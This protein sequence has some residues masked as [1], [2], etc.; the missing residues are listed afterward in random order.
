RR[1]R[2]QWLVGPCARLHL[3]EKTSHLRMSGKTMLESL[4]CPIQDH[5]GFSSGDECR[6]T[7][8]SQR[9]L[10]ISLRTQPCAFGL[11]A[12][13]ERQAF[14]CVGAVVWHIPASSVRGAPR[15]A[16]ECLVDEVD[17]LLEVLFQNCLDLG[18]LP[19]DN[20]HQIC[21]DHDAVTE[22][23]LRNLL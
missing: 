19:T 13:A 11:H 9:D 14:L 5:F 7:A 12:R 10:V 3:S 23:F 4:E 17:V 16:E 8:V 21:G 1:W 20:V 18:Q 6:M 22:V 15:L 2:R